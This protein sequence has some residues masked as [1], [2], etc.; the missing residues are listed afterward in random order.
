M[1]KF[2]E[3][4]WSRILMPA[5]TRIRE[6]LRTLCTLQQSIKLHIRQD[7]SLSFDQAAEIAD[8]AAVPQPIIRDRINRRKEILMLQKGATVYPL[9]SFSIHIQYWDNFPMRQPLTSLTSGDS[10]TDRLYNMHVMQRSTICASVA[11]AWRVFQFCRLRQ[12]NSRHGSVLPAS[13]L[14]ILASI[15]EALVNANSINGWRRVLTIVEGDISEELRQ[16]SAEE[17]R[18]PEQI[19]AQFRLPPNPV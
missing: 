5:K 1:V 6:E 2:S 15:L 4:T 3:H 16:L 19:K 10:P 18:N 11:A 9:T 8:W 14:K 7:V 17:N 12:F 13:A